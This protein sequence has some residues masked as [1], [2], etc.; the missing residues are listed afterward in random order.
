MTA[1]HE[2]D[3]FNAEDEDKLS[4]V[5]GCIFVFTIMVYDKKPIYLELILPRLVSG[6]SLRGVRVEV[7]WTARATTL[8]SPA[9]NT[10]QHIGQRQCGGVAVCRGRHPWQHT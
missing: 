8:L 3:E 2:W 4:R 10:E 7:L 9:R 5:R 1:K 6:P